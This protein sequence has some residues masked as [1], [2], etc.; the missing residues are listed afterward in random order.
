L[1]PTV[2][3]VA[4]PSGREITVTDTVGFV[5]HLPHQL[6]EAFRSTLEEIADADIV[7][8]LLD[9]SDESPI[10]QLSSVR[11]VLTEI[12][13]SDLREL[14]V[15]NKIDAAKPEVIA[16]LRMLI[17]EAVFI[18][19]KTGEGIDALLEVIDKKLAAAD[20]V[21]DLIL[22]YSAQQ[23][24]ARVHKVGQVQ[25]IE[26]LE[27][28]TRLVAAVPPGLAAELRVASNK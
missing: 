16:E 4:L 24:I 18:S 8:H 9:A 28:G 7:L 27:A 26:H 11:E 19:S 17:P 3:K 14:V 22:P 12:G 15:V 2:R 25:L 13:P 1:D 5:R 23:L 20:L 10:S 6:V 21:I